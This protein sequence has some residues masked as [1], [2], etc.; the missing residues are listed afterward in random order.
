M[1]EAGGSVKESGRQDLKDNE[2]RDKTSSQY[3]SNG[4]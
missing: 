4:N 3:M 2:Q 1:S